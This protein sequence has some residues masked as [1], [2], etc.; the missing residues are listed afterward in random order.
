[1][2]TTIQQHLC[3][4]RMQGVYQH[5]Y[6]NNNGQGQM[7]AEATM[8]I[9]GGIRGRSH[10]D[11]ESLLRTAVFHHSTCATSSPR[12]PGSHEASFTAIG[13]ATHT[14]Q[15]SS[16]ASDVAHI[17]IS[18]TSLARHCGAKIAAAMVIVRFSGPS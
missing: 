1:M 16:S 15:W 17:S 7:Q 10:W 8:P 4:N 5:Y 11:E 18:L 9:F 14:L 3:Q 13:L 2:A 6:P 12:Y